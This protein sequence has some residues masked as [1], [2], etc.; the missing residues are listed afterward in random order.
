MPRI[1]QNEERDTLRDLEAEIRAQRARHGLETSELF[2]EAIGVCPKTAWSYGK[3]PGQV[4]L[5]SMRK[6]VKAIHPD[7]VVVLKALG[8]TGQEIRRI[9]TN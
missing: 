3:D 1:R 9:S 2:G 4:R 8:Y 5:S 6:I 7:P